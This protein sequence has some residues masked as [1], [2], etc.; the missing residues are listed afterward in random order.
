M[1]GKTSSMKTSANSSAQNSNN[2]RKKVDESRE[3][4]KV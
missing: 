3:D 4:R 1:I 2:Y